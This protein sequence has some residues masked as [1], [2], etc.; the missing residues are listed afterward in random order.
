MKKNKEKFILERAVNSR[1]VSADN[2]TELYIKYC[3]I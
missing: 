3:S 1:V 2:K